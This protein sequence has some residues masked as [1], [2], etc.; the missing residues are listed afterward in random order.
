MQPAYMAMLHRLCKM[1]FK[2]ENSLRRPDI[3]G[4]LAFL[5]ERLSFMVPSRFTSL[6]RRVFDKARPAPS[7]STPNLA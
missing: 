3:A 1:A 7:A 6:G 2:Y 4:P 5:L